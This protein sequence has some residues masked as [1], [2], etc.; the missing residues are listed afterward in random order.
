MALSFITAIWGDKY[1]DDYVT[2][3]RRQVP[4]ITVLGRDRLL[5]EPTTYT[6]WWCKLEIFR[7]ENADLRPCLFID[8]DTFIL[9]SLD[10]FFELDHRYLWLIRDFTHPDT[11]SN[12]GLFIMPDDPISDL[13]WERSKRTDRSPSHGDGDYLK[14]FQHKRLQDAVTGIRSYKV[15]KL[16][17]DPRDTRICCFHGFPKPDK[18][19]GWA[20]EYWQCMSQ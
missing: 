15:D 4:G 5:L 6:Y 11:Q 12:S 16:Q 13:I 3:I 18:T 14:H 9:G 20:Q 7:P 8:L 10:P 19:E 2:A 1:S 17:D